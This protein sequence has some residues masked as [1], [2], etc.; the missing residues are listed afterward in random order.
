[1]TLLEPASARSIPWGD[2]NPE[3][4]LSA[5]A[6]CVLLL[7]F[8]LS[9]TDFF[10]VNVALPTIGRSLHASDA[11]LELVVGAYG[12][13]YAVLLVLGGRLGDAVGRKRLFMGGM[14]AFTLM[15]L[16]CA[17]SPSIGVLLVARALQGASAAL[18]VPQV[19]ATIQ[20]RTDGEARARAVGMYGATAGLSMVAGQLLGGFITWLNAFGTEW[21]GIFMVN[22]PVGLVG[23]VVARRS[24]PDTRSEL[25]SRIDVLGTAILALTLL[26]LLVPLTEGRALG[27]PTWSWLLLLFVPFGAS[28]FVNYERALERQLRMPLVPFSLMEHR[29]MRLGLA[30]AIP[31]FASFG[32]FMFLYAVVTQS[33][34]GLSALAAGATLAPLAA[35]FCAASL[36][37]ARAVVRYGRAVISVG[38]G[39]QA[40]GYSGL[41]VVLAT[42]WPHPSI[43]AAMPALVVAGFGQGL[44]VS[45]LL[46]VILS[47]VPTPRAGAGAGVLATGQQTSLALGVALIGSLFSALI[48][49][50]GVKGSALGVIG[51][52]IATACVVAF[53]SRRLPNPDSPAPAQESIIREDKTSVAGQSATEES[54]RTGEELVFV[55]V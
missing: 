47:E 38:A 14:A 21:R 49:V 2:P 36:V 51:I 1:M 33:Y 17:V 52:V 39:L 29:S 4:A 7:G 27:W 53:A 26:C 42:T 46:R 8:A 30:L 43:W 37:T 54:D 12:I 48:S 45:P 40:L 3:P 20:A 15:S 22:V 28:L 23:L 19:L 44:V 11:V 24:M 5:A 9:V 16:A 35:A 18:V 34:L 50:V 41:L 10:I 31:F 32:G 55:P 13:T 6:I 25:A